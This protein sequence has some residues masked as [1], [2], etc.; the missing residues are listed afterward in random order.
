MAKKQQGFPVPQRDEDDEKHTA[1]IAAA[2]GG[3]KKKGRAVAVRGNKLPVG[4]DAIERGYLS[5]LQDTTKALVAAEPLGGSQ[6]IIRVKNKRFFLGEHPLDAPLKVVVLATAAVQNYYEEKYDPDEKSSPVCWARAP[7]ESELAPPDDVPKKQNEVCAGCPQ[8]LPGSGERGGFT[9]ACASRRRLAVMF[10]G[11]ESDD[12]QWASLELSVTA[13]KGW[14]AYVKGLAA[15]HN[16]PY[17]M[18]VTSLDFED[19]KSGDYWHVAMAFEERVSKARPDWLKP[20]KGVKPTDPGAFYTSVLGRRVKEIVDTRALMAAPALI[21]DAPKRGAKGAK[22]RVPVDQVKKKKKAA[23]AQRVPVG[24]FN[25][26][27]A[28]ARV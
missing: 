1:L 4:L 18:A 17:F 28:R 20:E 16:I 23:G 9:R 26:G 2:R 22:R 5:D 15:V 25:G 27:R 21:A 14:S 24:G 13:I 3:G 19:D 10:I 6:N 7:S 11:D 12:P 8:N